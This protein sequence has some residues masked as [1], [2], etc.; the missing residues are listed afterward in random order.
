MISGILNINDELYEAAYVDGMRN[1][2]QEIFYITIPSM[3]PQMLFGAVMAVVNAFNSAGLGV[4]LSGSN[5]TPGYAGSVIVNHVDDFGFIRY[6]MG[7]AAALSV[8]LL[9]II[10]LASKLAYKLFGDD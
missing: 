3:K 4:Q 6:E 5:P 2:F 1:R 7:Y 9:L 10:T 8:V